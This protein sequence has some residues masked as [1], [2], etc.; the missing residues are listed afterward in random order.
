[1]DI[2]KNKLD[3]FSQPP[4]NQFQMDKEFKYEKW[5]YKIYRFLKNTNKGLLW[6][7]QKEIIQ[8][9]NDKLRLIFFSLMYP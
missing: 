1:M 4:S 3:T 9:N 7:M 6:K 8:E 2:I 5:N